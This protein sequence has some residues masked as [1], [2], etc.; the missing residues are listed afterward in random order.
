MGCES[1]GSIFAS[2]HVNYA[3][4][5][6]LYVRAMES[7]QTKVW[8]LPVHGQYSMIHVC[9]ASN[10]TWSDMFSDST[11]M[12]YRHSHGGLTGITLDFNATM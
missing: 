6:L 12:R 7:L 8:S 1:N 10:S 5:G 9:G 11:C 2:A 3:R 4:Y